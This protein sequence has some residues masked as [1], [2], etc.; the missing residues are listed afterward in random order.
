MRSKLILLFVFSLSL[1]GIKGQISSNGL[2]LYLPLNGNVNDSSSFANNGVN[3]G[4]TPATDR[5]GRSKKAMYFNGTSRIEIPNSVSLNLTTNRTLSCWVYIP[6]NVTQNWYSTLLGKPEPLYSST[7][8]LHLDEYSA[9]SN[10][11]RYKFESLFASG[12]THYQVFSKQLYTD[13]KNSWLHL[14][15]TYDTISGYSKIYFNGTISDSTYIG[16]KIANSSTLPLYIGCGETTSGSY[17]TFFNGYMDEVRLYNRAISKN[18][19]Y[20][21]YME[22]LCSTSIK[23]DTTTYYIYTES[24]KSLSPQYQLIKTDNL[25]TKVGNCDSIINHY[26]K[27]EYAKVTG[28]TS[29]SD[30]QNK[31]K[32]YPNPAK[33]YVTI[34]FGDYTKT[35]GY[36]MV[37]R[38]VIGK[39]VYSAP[40]IHE[41]TNLGV[42]EWSG[43][44][45]YIVQLFDKQ[46]NLIETQ[47]VIVR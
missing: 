37:I 39:S 31:L 30:T 4:S 9:Y 24:F 40:I 7:Y 38:D 26:A 46:N 20:N 33:D 17:Q 2:V 21:M 35:N 18:E 12:Y 32:I 41:S 19:V 10:Q 36:F 47:K 5:F 13:Y 25:K 8:L 3:H 16:R 27:F 42:K 14:A 28:I 43:S 11:Y 15:V 6:S 22:G 1:F 34:T 29:A 45:L 23:N 44:G